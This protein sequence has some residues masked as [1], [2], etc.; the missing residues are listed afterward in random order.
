M[1]PEPEE[2]ETAGELYFGLSI[3]EYSIHRQKIRETFPK[4]PDVDTQ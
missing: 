1:R 4:N 2:L 3:L